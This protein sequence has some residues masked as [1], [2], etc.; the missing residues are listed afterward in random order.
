MLGQ[1]TIVRAGFCP[2]VGSDDCREELRTRL[3]VDEPI[4]CEVIL[5]VSRPIVCYIALLPGHDARPAA[6]RRA[7]PKATDCARMESG[8]ACG[9]GEEALDLRGRRRARRTESDAASHRGPRACT[10]RCDP[11]SLSRVV[12]P[13]RARSL[14]H[15]GP[16]A[17][18]VTGAGCTASSGPGR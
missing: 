15:I 8:R 18:P 14:P 12:T 2:H 13:L 9:P 3:T 17:D 6:L 11:R 16:Q 4:D 1:S 7:A 5:I 10:G